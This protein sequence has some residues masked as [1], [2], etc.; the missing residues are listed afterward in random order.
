MV[1][2]H[3]HK[4]LRQAYTAQ[5]TNSKEQGPSW[6]ADMSN[7]LSFLIIEQP[8]YSRSLMTSENEL[9]LVEQIASFPDLMVLLNCSFNS[10]PEWLQ[11]LLV[12]ISD[13]DQLVQASRINDV[14]EHLTSSANHLDC[15]INKNDHKS[16]HTFP[17]VNRLHL[18]KY[19]T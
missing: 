12:N 4:T 6:E 10:I 17:F 8:N 18:P 3:N 14:L 1:R 7:I 2:F 16:A 15:S 13:L 9:I 5:W 19:K 11:E